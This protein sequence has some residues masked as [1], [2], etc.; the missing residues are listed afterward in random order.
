MMK[1]VMVAALILMASMVVMAQDVMEDGSRVVLPLEVQQCDLPNAPPPIP[2]E[3]VKADLL[4][5]NKHVKQFQ[6]DVVVYRTC[7]GVEN[8]EKLDGLTE[9]DD[10]SM[11]NVQA[12]LNA[13]NY[14]VDMEER[15]AAMFNEALRAWKK[16]GSPS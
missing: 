8:Q 1:R 15:V 13:Y 10:L 14:S 16:A 7:L 9:R 4:V 6:A 3:S 2:E 12:L 11:G 5:A